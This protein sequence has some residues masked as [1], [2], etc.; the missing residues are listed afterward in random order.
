MK[1]SFPLPATPSSSSPPSPNHLSPL[2][3]I[4]DTDPGYILSSYLE[5]S[6]FGALRSLCTES[7]ELTSLTSSSD[8]FMLL[9]SRRPPPPPPPSPPPK[10]SS[11]ATP[12]SKPSATAFPD[13]FKSEYLR[14]HAFV[15]GIAKA[16]EHAALL[17]SR[18]LPSVALTPLSVAPD[19]YAEEEYYDE[20]FLAFECILPCQSAEQLF[21]AD[22]RSTLPS[23]PTM[24]CCPPTMCCTCCFPNL[25]QGTAENCA[26]LASVK[27]EMDSAELAAWAR[28][29]DSPLL[30]APWKVREE[31]DVTRRSAQLAAQ[32]AS[33]A[34]LLLPDTAG[35]TSSALGR[36]HAS[37]GFHGAFSSRRGE[38]AYCVTETAVVLS[39]P[40]SS[41]VSASPPASP[42]DMLCGE[43]V[44][45]LVGGSS[46]M[47]DL[48]PYSCICCGNDADKTLNQLSVAVLLP[49]AST[50]AP[51]L[52]LSYTTHHDEE[53]D[54]HFYETTGWGVT[55]DKSTSDVL[56]E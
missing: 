21:K 12:Q 38:N 16:E 51:L 34:S 8:L 13:P 36:F 18:L 43:R 52:S 32:H 35:V 49:G 11:Q 45:V 40:R 42:P 37:I 53:D 5:V 46:H 17:P 6:S 28:V 23:P 44:L 9:H 33:R 26:K 2:L 39:L 29:Q 15:K 47:F 50:F 31:S 22:W 27:K 1:R 3:L 48:N 54:A 41:L 24:C 30:L 25:N 19:E 55:V 7:S 4:L 56:E 14:T 20:H 10:P